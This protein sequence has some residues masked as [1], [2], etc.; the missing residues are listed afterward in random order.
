MTLHIDNVG[1]SYTIVTCDISLKLESNSPSQVQKFKSQYLSFMILNSFTC[2]EVTA[3]QSVFSFHLLSL[4]WLVRS[5][6]AAVLV[7]AVEPGC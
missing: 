2:T 3:I 7:V 5:T 6:T 4:S 1:P